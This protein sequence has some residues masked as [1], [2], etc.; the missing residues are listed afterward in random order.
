LNLLVSLI[1]NYEHDLIYF[2]FMSAF[3]GWLAF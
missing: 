3:Y 2:V 1:E